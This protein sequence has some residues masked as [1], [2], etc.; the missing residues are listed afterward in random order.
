MRKIIYISV[1]LLILFPAAIKAQ[2]RVIYEDTALLQKSDPVE[3]VEEVTTVV[4]REDVGDEAHTMDTTLAQNNLQL[5][6]D[7]IRKWRNLKEYAYSKYLDSLLR[8]KKKEAP[9]EEASQPPSGGGFL[10][11]ILESG[12]V[13]ILLWTLAILFVLFIIYRLF[14]ADAVFKGKPK[15]LKEAAGE[16]EEEMITQESD[17]DALIRQALQNSNYRQAVRYQYLRT[18]HLLAVKN[19]VILAPDKTNFQYV[20][21]ISNYNHQQDFAA[22]TLNYEYVWYGEFAIEKEIYQRIETNFISL[23]QKL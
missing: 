7:S 20:R 16:V 23:N 8:N 19:M 14:L 10:N 12:F 17:F 13:N 15:S 4:P 18:L 21:E 3:V 9:P 1:L 5:A 6:Y 2:E 22:L 11:S